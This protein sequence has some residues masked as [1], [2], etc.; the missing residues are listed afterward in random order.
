MNKRLQGFVA[1]ILCCVLFA[2][3]SVFAKN[4][5]ETIQA[6][7]KD[8]K[9]YVDGVKIN[10][11]DANGNTVEPFIYNGTTYLPVRAVGE[12][13]NK[14]VTWDGATSSV[15]LGKKAGETTLFLEACPPYEKNMDLYLSENGQSFLMAGEDY[16][17]GMVT[18]GWNG[19]YSL[20]NLNGKYSALDCT[21][22]HVS[23]NQTEKVLSFIVDGKV[24]K[25]ITLEPECMPKKISIPLNNGLQLKILLSCD[26]A[27]N[28]GNGS[29]SA[30]IGN[31][32]LR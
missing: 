22:G 13:I 29:T 3:I 23:S 21:V 7:Y 16:S 32:I 28:N 26:G 30:G 17:D 11:K 1:G 9:I 25:K 20:S 12:A 31:M 5:S 18:S 15:Y 19:S 4:T 2:G 24:I 27:F 6:L 10:P 8:I 14:Q